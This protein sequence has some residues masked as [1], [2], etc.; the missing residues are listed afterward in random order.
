L[1]APTH[2]AKNSTF[3][4]L[5]IILPTI[6]I[7]LFLITI[8]GFLPVGWLFIAIS[9]NFIVSGFGIKKMIET[10]QQ[11]NQAQAVLNKYAQLLLHIESEKFEN[12]I[13][14]DL[15][16]R[17]IT[18]NQKSAGQVIKQIANYINYFE[19][20]VNLIA[21]LFLNGLVL[22]NLQFAFRIEKWRN[23]YKEEVFVW[24]EVI[25]EF[26]ALLS[27]ANLAYN[28]PQYTQPKI[29]TED[30]VLEAE[31]LGHVLL[32][33]ET[34]IN[35]EVSFKGYGQLKLITGANM[36]G[37]ST[38][39]RTVSINLILAM[40]GAMVCAKNFRFTPIPI[41]TSMRT[42]DSLQAN[43][44]FFYAELKRLKMLID[45][46]SS[47]NKIFIV[48]DEILKGTNS[49][50]QHIGSEA[51][52]RQIIKL[53]GVGLIATHDISL[54]KLAKEYPKNLEN[55]CFE[56][57]IKNDELSFDYRLRKGINQNLNATFL[58]KKMGITV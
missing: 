40:A 16:K 48:L 35:N 43:E 12:P 15:Q 21:G 7:V 51:L 36:A 42:K 19:N 8:V 57:E 39:L 55:Q 49:A 1:E 56:I 22:W 44:S 2:F 3:S 47:G 24:F 34:R 45:T 37:K 18:Q 13:L 53:G 26:D 28:Q 5:L 11:V 4:L 38:Y 31:D 23:V 25:S 30:F 6:S 32:N 58:M 10:H 46:L 52:I 33:E 27:L 20:G 17:L 29:I 41:Y 14:S 50:D 54:G 9:V